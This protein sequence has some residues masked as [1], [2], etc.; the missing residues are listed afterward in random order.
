L[1]SRRERIG[2]RVLGGVALAAVALVG[3]IQVFGGP[4]GAPCRDSYSCRGFLVGGVDCVEDV[5]QSYCSRYCHAD[6]DCPTGWR[7][8]GAHPT[9][10]SVHTSAVGLICIRPSR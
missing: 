4:V 7:C 8:D 5:G 3:A 10:L 9:V 1:L 6:A 2:R